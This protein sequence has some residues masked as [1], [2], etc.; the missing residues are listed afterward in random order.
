MA[1]VLMHASDPLRMMTPADYQPTPLAEFGLAPTGY[2]VILAD[3]TQPRLEAH[4]GTVHPQRLFQYMRLT[5]SDTVYLMSRFVGQAWEH[6]WEHVSA[7][8]MGE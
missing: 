5:G 6:V 1:L 8:P 2:R 7:A 4:F 3:P